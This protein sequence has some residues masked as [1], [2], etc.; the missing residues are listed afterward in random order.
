VQ[1]HHLHEPFVGLE[2]P[3]LLLRDVAT[4]DLREIPVQQSL[5]TLH[6]G[7]ALLQ[8]LSKVANIGEA[9][10]S[11][12]RI[13][14][15]STGNVVVGEKATKHG[16]HATISPQL[17]IVHKAFLVLLPAPLVAQ[18]ADQL[19]SRP[20]HETRG[21]C[22]SHA[23]LVP[24]FQRGFQHQRKVFRLVRAEDGLACQIRSADTPL[25][26]RIT[27]CDRLQVVSY[28]NRHVCW[29]EGSAMERRAA[30]PKQQ[31]NAIRRDGR[32]RTA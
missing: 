5:H 1:R 11:E 3:L 27:H 9:A 6:L 18:R 4:T 28:E 25:G 19:L 23:V 32:K 12:I 15:Q 7:G 31:R 14:E 29:L 21:K 26:K 20:S 24:R 8:Q 13:L 10:F 17:V 16:E 2:T 30:L 22:R